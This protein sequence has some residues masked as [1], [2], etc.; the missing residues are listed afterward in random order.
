MFKKMLVLLSFVIF[1]LELLSDSDFEKLQSSIICPMNFTITQGGLP[2]DTYYFWDSSEFTNVAEAVE[3]WGIY[4]NLNEFSIS[5][6]SPN[7]LSCGGED[8][9]DTFLSL[10]CS[11]DEYTETEKDYCFTWK[12]SSEFLSSNSLIRYNNDGSYSNPTNWLNSSSFGTVSCMPDLNFPKPLTQYLFDE[13]TG[14]IYL[15]E[16]YLAFYVNRIWESKQV[17]Y[18]LTSDEIVSIRSL[19]GSSAPST[20]DINYSAQ[21]DSIIENTSINSNILKTLTNTFDDTKNILS[22]V[23]NIDNR[24]NN[25][26]DDLDVLSSSTPLNSIIDN[27][28]D[29][30]SFSSSFETTLSDTFSAYSDIFGFGSDFGTAPEPIIFEMFDTEYV[31]FDISILGESNIVLI[32]DTFLLFSYLYGFIFVFRGS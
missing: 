20:T 1:S 7:S 2:F 14:T 8:D 5:V 9:F 26:S 10:S 4:G 31:L 16:P 27:T 25:L 11:T 6:L 17:N 21:L 24:Q 3:E 23:D 22:S 13:D 18:N 12:F 32:R 15:D 28:A 29:L 30:N 19:C